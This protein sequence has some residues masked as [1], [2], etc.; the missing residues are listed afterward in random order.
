MPLVNLPIIDIPFSRI[1]MDI[2]GPVERS[3]SSNRYILVVVDYATHYPEVFPLRNIKTRHVVNALVQLFSRVGLPKE[4]IT[5]QA[6]TL[7]LG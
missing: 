1:A 6:L 5:D 3:R 2:V 7:H 4:I